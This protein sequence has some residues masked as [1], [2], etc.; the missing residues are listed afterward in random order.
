MV[1]NCQQKVQSATSLII[2]EE[3][4]TSMCG[5]NCSSVVRLVLNYNEYYSNAQFNLVSDFFAGFVM[6]E[7]AKSCPSASAIKIALRN[8]L[9][10]M[11]SRKARRERSI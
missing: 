3:H 9:S 10:A 5:F 2:E 4:L 8:K 11:E 7:K 6:K 1:R